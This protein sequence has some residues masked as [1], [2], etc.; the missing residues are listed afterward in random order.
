MTESNFG[1]SVLY[2]QIDLRF[3]QPRWNGE[4]GNILGS[5]WD[6]NDENTSLESELELGENMI[7]GNVFFPVLPQMRRRYEMNQ[8]SQ[9]GQ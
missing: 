9:R 8:M 3:G 4:I 6:L 5:I 2:V 7:K 1:L